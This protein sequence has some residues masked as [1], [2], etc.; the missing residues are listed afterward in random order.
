[1][2]KKLTLFQKINRLTLK[3][4]VKNL[5][6]ANAKLKDQVRSLKGKINNQ[7]TKIK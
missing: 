3:K 4:Q 2:S 7:V 1:M 5:R 6:D